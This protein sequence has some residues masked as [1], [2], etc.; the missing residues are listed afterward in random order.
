MSLSYIKL[1]QY[2]I[3]NATI[4]LKASIQN[5]ECVCVI[6]FWL[7]KF[8]SE[9]EE[10]GRQMLQ[11]KWWLAVLCQRDQPSVFC[12][13]KF[14]ERTSGRAMRESAREKRY[15]CGALFAIAAT[16]R[17]HF[18]SFVAVVRKLARANA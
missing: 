6:V 7:C 12:I 16:Q 11:S 13:C 15:V 17:I 3:I 14:K 10:S 2:S 18:N 1:D 8:A 9:M 4:I 5:Q